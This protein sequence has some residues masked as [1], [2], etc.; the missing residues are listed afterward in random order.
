MR[1]AMGD[2]NDGVVV[3]EFPKNLVD[4]VREQGESVLDT[5]MASYVL[6]YYAHM[7]SY[8]G[9]TSTA[10]EAHAKAE[11]QRKAVQE[12]W[13]GRWFRRA[14]L[15]PHLEW[16]GDDRLWLEPQPWAIIGGAATP[17]QRATLVAA[18]DELIRRP[19]PIGAMILNQAETTPSKPDGVL[20]NG[21]IWPSINGTLI[22][23]L[24]MAG[25]ASAWD[26]W[27]KNSLAM[28]AEAYPDIWYGIWSGPDTY[29]SVLSKHPG[30]TMFTEP[31]LTGRKDPSDWGVNWTDYPVMNLH[32]HAWQLYSAAKLL[33]VEFHETGVR[34]NPAL[35]L[36]EYEFASPLLG[37]SKSPKGYSGWYAPSAAGRWTVEIKLSDSERAGLK[38]IKINGSIEPFPHDAQTIQFV[39]ESHLD[40]PLR[41]EIS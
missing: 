6:D 17:Y 24:A 22:W 12:N 41:W 4:E 28:H 31:S 9:A 35:P 13:S 7:L 29:N 40:A 26:E 32:P 25:G 37:F 20:E 3:V 5:A 1:L 2:W 34:F 38:Q 18:L 27:K 10:A 39:G 14:W 36:T 21:G 16:I 11:G 33:G 30:Q 19:S 8:V 15:G 23:S